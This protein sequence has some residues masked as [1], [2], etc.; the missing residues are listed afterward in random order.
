MRCWA[1]RPC[2]K[3]WARASSAAAG[4]PVTAR[5]TP[6]GRAWFGTAC[7]CSTFWAG[8]AV[9]FPAMF[10]PGPVTALDQRPYQTGGTKTCIT[11][12]VMDLVPAN[13]TNTTALVL[14]T[15]GALS[16]WH[17]LQEQTQT[18]GTVQ[19]R[20]NLNAAHYDATGLGQPGT[21]AWG[22]ALCNGQNG[23][24]DLRGMFVLGHNPDRPGLSTTA[25]GDTGGEENKTLTTD[26]MPAHNHVASTGQFGYNQLLRKA[27]LGS[28]S[29]A[30][31]TDG[32]GNGGTEPD[33]LS[34]QALQPAGG[35]QPFDNRPPFYV[36]AVQEWVGYGA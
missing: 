23:T 4:C 3:A 28:L 22:W 18:V 2:C 34:S 11:N 13:A 31:G 17:R 5:P 6:S 10:V 7:S 19:Y 9:T 8:G 16:F 21:P 12:Q 36:L 14:N 26:Q 30:S 1:C 15:W 20:T 35:S 29:T 33:I 24:A 32:G 25:V 27:P